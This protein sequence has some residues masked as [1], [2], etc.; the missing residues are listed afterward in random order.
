MMQTAKPWHRYDLAICA[1]VL[2]WLASFRR[3][4]RQ[5]EMRSILVVV[6]DV[7]VHQAFQVAFIDN[8]HVVEQV[9]AAAADPT[10]SDSV[11]PW[12]SEAGSLGL[13]VEALHRLDYFVT[14][15]C[16]AI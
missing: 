1:A 2:L 6:T 14:E 9:P 8:D 7:F 15:V 11:L 13:N 3:S 16:T 12:T 10:L 5:P 4:F